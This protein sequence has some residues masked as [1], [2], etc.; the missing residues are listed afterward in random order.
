[1]SYLSIDIGTTLVKCGLFFKDGRAVFTAAE[2]P[3]HTRGGMVEQDARDWLNAAA[4]GVRKLAAQTEGEPVQAICVGS[5]GITFVPISGDGTPIRPA[6]TWL[7]LRAEEECQK[8]LRKFSASEVFSVTGK[9]CSP[10]YSLPKWM[11]LK[12]HEE[13]V[14]ARASCLLFPA[15]YL[16]FVMTGKCVTDYTLASGSM[17]FDVRK[18]DWSEELLGA[19]GIAREKLPSVEPFGGKIGLLKPDAAALFGLPAG[20]PVVLGGQDQKLAAIG[21]GLEPGTV[22]VSLG[23]AAAVSSLERTSDASVFAFDGERPVYESVL[24]TCGAAIKW[25]KECLGFQTYAEMDALAERTAESGGVRFEPDFVSGANLKGLTLGTE[26]GQIVCALYE[27]IAQR[28]A[29]LIPSSAQ[30]VVLFGGGSNSSPLCRMIAKA[31]GRSVSVSE[32]AET[33][34]LGG[35]ILASDRKI[36]PARRKC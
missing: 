22:T 11:W 17:A 29:E 31:L 32:T 26:R 2:Y 20:I 1:M 12:A 6:I 19:F 7:D 33:A 14:Y 30:K 18:L 10:G 25:L 9:K 34:A 36:K 16:N 3:L 23:T 27:G 24:D 15:D 5:Q 8:I 28:I 21:A 13:Q 4:E 35:A